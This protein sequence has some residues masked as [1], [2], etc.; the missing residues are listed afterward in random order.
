MNAETI[1]D[2]L[3]LLPED[4]IAETAQLRRKP[5]IKLW[6]PLLP[7]AACLTLLLLGTFALPRPIAESA[8]DKAA[9]QLAM[10]REVYDEG[11]AEAAEEEAAETRSR[12]GAGSQAPLNARY[13]PAPV[14]GTPGHTLISTRAQLDAYLEGNDALAEACRQ[15]DDAYFTD[16]QL[17]LL[18]TSTYRPAASC[19]S[20]TLLPMAGGSWFLES[21][22]DGAWNLELRDMVPEVS[23][24]DLARQ[25]ILLEL[26]GRPI[27]P[28]D[29][30]TVTQNPS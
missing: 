13:F 29:T 8:A 6:K 20:D 22:G 12:K 2:A 10:A 25:H 17:I 3:T 14:D 15:Y 19:S 9:P 4:L 23:S 11:P 21:A 27:A 28:E 18:L 16:H 7:I 26:P 1:H 30:I 24:E 5:K